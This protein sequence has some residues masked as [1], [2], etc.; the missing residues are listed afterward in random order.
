VDGLLERFRRD[1]PDLPILKMAY[2]GLTHVGEDTRIE[3]FMHQAHQHLARSDRTRRTLDKPRRMRYNANPLEGGR[4][5]EPGELEGAGVR[6]PAD[7]C[8]SRP[9]G[10]VHEEF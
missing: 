10:C 2:D 7:S 8:H 9:V 4:L 5:A 6:L 3:A 1:H